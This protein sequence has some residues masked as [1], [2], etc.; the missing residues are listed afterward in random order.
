MN[1]KYISRLN[2]L[3]DRRLIRMRRPEWL[4]VTEKI[5]LRLCSM[6][7]KRKKTISQYNYY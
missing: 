3:K 1:K 4:D 2:Q 5:L 6:Y 7:I